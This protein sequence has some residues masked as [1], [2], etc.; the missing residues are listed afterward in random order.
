MADLDKRGLKSSGVNDV[1]L[2]DGR[3][4]PWAEAFTR[5]SDEGMAAVRAKREEEGKC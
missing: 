3:L 5:L 4:V 1:T 2:P